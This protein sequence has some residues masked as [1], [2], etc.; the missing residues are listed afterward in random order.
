MGD[1]E[2]LFNRPTLNAYASV[3]GGKKQYSKGET[4]ASASARKHK[5]STRSQ[6]VKR[7]P[8]PELAY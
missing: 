3:A 4:P 1:A 8:S 2:K 6:S 7:T 5:S